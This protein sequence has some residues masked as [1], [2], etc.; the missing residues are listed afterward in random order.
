MSNNSMMAAMTIALTATVSVGFASQMTP[1][2]IYGDDHRADVYQVTD[3]RLL[4]VADST[5]ALIAKKDMTASGSGFK[6]NS[7]S[8]AKQMGLCSDEPFANQP[9]A[10]NCSGSLI[11]EDLVMTAGHCVDSS[12]C[13]SYYF[14]FNFKMNSATSA[15]VN[16]SADDVYS[17]Q[18]VVARELTNK[19]D[20]AI[21]KLDRR[22]RGHRPLVL[23]KNNAEVG[24]DVF[25]VGHPS[26]LPTKI[27]GG[28]Q[29]RSQAQGYFVAN[30]DTYG[31]NSGSAVFSAK[32][33]EVVGILVRGAQDF[34]YDRT[35]KC[36]RS[37][38]CPDTGCRGEDVTN[39]NFVTDYL[40]K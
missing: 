37:N 32:T 15:N 20:Y 39:I 28:A 17:C 11:G 33:N 8:F 23:A 38:Y 34:A 36:Y 5:V 12:S 19:Q 6:V 4:D 14:A 2:V 18:S 3:S 25:V 35:N 21:V 22:V 1:K 26:G 9:A 7:Q 16:L 24:D 31:G 27:A 10:A 30:L 13:G 40:N 29:V